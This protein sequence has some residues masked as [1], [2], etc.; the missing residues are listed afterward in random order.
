MSLLAPPPRALAATGPG[1]RTGTL[2]VR[3]VVTTATYVV[4]GAVLVLLVVLLAPAPSVTTV[5]PAA[6][7]TSVPALAEYDTTGGLIWTLYRDAGGS[8]AP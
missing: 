6:P 5:V 8:V 1:R 4:V 3:T 2:D 7:P